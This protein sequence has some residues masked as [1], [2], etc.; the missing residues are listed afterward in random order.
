MVVGQLDLIMA[1][2]N[3][4]LS[5]NDRNEDFYCATA[6]HCALLCELA[7]ASTEFHEKMAKAGVVEAFLVFM[8]VAGKG[9]NDEMAIEL[10]MSAVFGISALVSSPKTGE[11]CMA[12]LLFPA[13]RL[14]LFMSLLRLPA[15]DINGTYYNGTI[16]VRTLQRTAAPEITPEELQVGG[17]DQD[18]FLERCAVKPDSF[19]YRNV[20]R[21]LGLLLAHSEMAERV[22]QA[23]APPRIVPTCLFALRGADDQYVNVYGYLLVATFSKHLQLQPGFVNDNSIVNELLTGCRRGSSASGEDTEEQNVA[24]ELHNVGQGGAMWSP[25]TIGMNKYLLS[26]ISLTNF[27]ESIREVYKI[28]EDSEPS[29]SEEGKGLTTSNRLFMRKLASVSLKDLDCEAILSSHKMSQVQEFSALLK[30]IVIHNTLVA[31][32]VIENNKK[33]GLVQLNSEGSDVRLKGID[34]VPRELRVMF[35]TLKSLQ[36][37]SEGML[38]VVDQCLD[39]NRGR[40]LIVAI[41][42][43]LSG[44]TYL[45]PLCVLDPFSVYKIVSKAPEWVH[46]CLMCLLCNTLS[47]EDR[48]EKNDEEESGEMITAQSDYLFP[49]IST[50]TLKTRQYTLAALAN[51]GPRKRF[52]PFIVNSGVFRV[53]KPLPSRS[54]FVEH[55]GLVIE[56]M[57]L[58]TNM[59]CMED[60][61]LDVMTEPMVGFLRD[62]LKYSSKQILYD[63]K[64]P[65][66]PDIQYE[67]VTAT[68]EEE[69]VPPLGLRI[70]WEVPPYVSEVLPDT[71]A[72]ALEQPLMECDELVE[73]NGVDVTEMEQTEIEPFFETRP[74]TLVFRRTPERRPRQQEVTMQADEEEEIAHVEKLD[75]YGDADQYLECFNLALLTLHN[76][77]TNRRNHD[78]LLAEPKIL[79]NMLEIITSEVLAPSLRKI[80]FSLLTTFAEHKDI[81]GRIFQEMA[82]YFRSCEK[83]DPALQKYI[84][85]C[86]NL[87]YT[88][89]KPEE[90]VPDIGMMMFVGKLAELETTDSASMSLV[91]VL[92]GMS[93]APVERRHQFICR[94]TMVVTVRFIEDPDQWEVQ[95]RAFEAAY[96]LTLGALDPL[97]WASLTVV[98]RMA[99]AAG[100]ARQFAG[101]DPVLQ[102]PQT[103]F[104]NSRCGLR[105]CVWGTRFW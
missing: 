41:L 86:A 62:V 91:E 99:K 39:T 2:V 102:S 50:S 85:V 52:L 5:L 60:T 54:Y 26:M 80:T 14:Q 7:R 58:L 75:T 104:S 77:A 42:E 17:L 4:N 98:P 21:S 71:P 90:V 100:K 44:L 23:V 72:S 3:S 65:P 101:R 43:C 19:L 66:V 29:D 15:V 63:L 92:H 31:R 55:F 8:T 64:G 51:L 40:E 46:S 105:T 25:K 82:E 96:F 35:K 81:S 47:D 24:M 49:L 38:E 20:I 67:Y 88:S 32:I 83:G 78:L 79:D 59:T 34:M 70:R 76:L 37:K 13:T 89:M 87:F 28:N 18:F 12:S 93:R 61:H 69:D 10:L 9:V 103:G 68:F 16:G 84:I 48:V 73:V 1:S 97:L 6:V 22:M 56:C 53:I 95:L 33:G 36:H 30:V 74:L 27:A 57:R 94:E 11:Q 45:S